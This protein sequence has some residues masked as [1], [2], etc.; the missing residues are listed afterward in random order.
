MICISISSVL[1]VGRPITIFKIFNQ[2][3]NRQNI[4]IKYKLNCYNKVKLKDKMN[5]T[6]EISGQ[7]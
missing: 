1:D 4:C 3:K 6:S 7:G 2:E 5:L